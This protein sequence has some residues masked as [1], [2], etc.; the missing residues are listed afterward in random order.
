MGISTYQSYCGAQI[1][2]AIGLSESFLDRYFTGTTSTTEGAGIQEIAEET[3][4]RHRLAFGNAPIYECP[5][6]GRGIRL[7][8]PRR[9]P[10]L[11][12]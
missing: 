2:N 8:R 9:R 4:R 3:V 6:H 11:D 12:T 7:P 5:G 1:F 10:Y